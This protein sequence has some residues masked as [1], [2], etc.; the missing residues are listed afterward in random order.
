[1]TDSPDLE[2]RYRRLLV[3]YPRAFRREHEEEIVWVLMTG[4]EEGRWRPGLAESA[5][6]IRSATCMRLRPGMPR[7]ARTVFA[8]VRL[9]YVGAAVELC[10]LTTVVATLGS[11][12]SSIFQR[13]PGYTAAQWHAEVL[14]HIVP[15]EVGVSIATGVWLWM[16][17][18]NGRGHRWARV[19]FA[20]FFGLT[21]MSLLNGV[22]Q[23]AA[24]YAP[25]DVIAGDALWLVALATV[26]LIFNKESGPHY[27]QPPAHG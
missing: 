6:L 21:T 10:T 12:R 19:V 1:M 8:A 24:T 23:N 4:A 11:L 26:A 22:A 16:A 27:T 15:M 20:L 25:A 14:G 18:A 13:N 9:M 17:W 3:W 7:S 2:R 5:D